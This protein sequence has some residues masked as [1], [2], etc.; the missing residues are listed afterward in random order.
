MAPNI[1]IPVFKGFFSRAY[2]ICS[3]C[4]IDGKNPI[5]NWNVHR[6]QFWKENVGKDQKII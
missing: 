4:Y 1:S 6:E 5:Y 2:K 3:K